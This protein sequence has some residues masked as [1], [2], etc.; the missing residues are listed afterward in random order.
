MN[1][2]FQRSVEEMRMHMQ[3]DSEKRSE[4]LLAHNQRL[5]IELQ[6]HAQKENHDK[7]AEQHKQ[8]EMIVTMNAGISQLRS[9]LQEH[10]MKNTPAP[11]QLGPS[12]ESMADEKMR[13]LKSSRTKEMV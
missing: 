8:Q 10:K 5:Q 6:S 12:F 13:I 2:Q 4:E 3:T 9:K 1:R 11:L 7:E